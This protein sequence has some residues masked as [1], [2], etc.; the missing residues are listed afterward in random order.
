VMA[1]GKGAPTE[2]KWELQQQRVPESKS[3]KYL[4]VI[5]Q[6][7]RS[8][9][10]WNV[11]RKAKGK[12]CL[13]TMWW[14]GARQG[15]LS[16]RTGMKLLQTMV[17]P[18]LAYG[19]ELA[20]LS[21]NQQRQSEV[22]QNAAARQ[23]LG[24][25]RRTAADMLRGELGWITV[26]ARRTIARLA[27][28]HRLQCMPLTRLAADVFASGM[29]HELAS[30]SSAAVAA[31]GAVKHAGGFCHAI[32]AVLARLDL[33]H[34][35]TRHT[36]VTARH[37]KHMVTQAVVVEQQRQWGERLSKRDDA[38]WYRGV[39]QQWGMERYLEIGGQ[40]AQQSRGRRVRAQMRLGVAPLHANINK[41]NPN[42]P[43]T[44]P[45]CHASVEDETHAICVCSFHD[46]ARRTLYAAVEQ[47]WERG[48]RTGEQWWQRASA[49]ATGVWSGMGAR[50]RAMWLLSFDGPRIVVAVHAFLAAL[51]AA[52]EK[53]GYGFA[54]AQRK[55]YQK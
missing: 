43:P 51:A 26:E 11:A 20:R 48:E 31:T 40:S 21:E 32:R 12:G 36:Y 52:K 17:W 2:E 41:T 54:Y 29:Q 28:F 5:M 47:E 14:C 35:F 30:E 49:S 8:W 53:A 15:A 16:V 13:P 39:K 6:S 22:V 46:V 45:H 18:V 44:C 37:W 4:G 10:M 24:V 23:I 34:F 27:F 33:H 19:G 1:V 9:H 25:G 50:Q 7:S 55:A 38:E 3:Y 42:E